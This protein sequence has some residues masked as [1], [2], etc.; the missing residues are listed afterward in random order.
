MLLLRSLATILLLPWSG[1]GVEAWFGQEGTG[2]E[3]GT[4]LLK[5]VAEPEN[6]DSMGG[7]ENLACPV[8]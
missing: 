8:I 7:W 4:H 5:V 3:G 2:L 6:E 1:L